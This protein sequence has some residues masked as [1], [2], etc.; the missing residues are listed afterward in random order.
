MKRDELRSLAERLESLTD[1][2]NRDYRYNETLADAVA[3]LRQI[4][5]AQPVAWRNEVRGTGEHRNIPE[6]EWRTYGITDSKTAADAHIE[7]CRD[8][9]EGRAIPLFTLPLED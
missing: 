7:N 6:T 3:F 5:E 4:A 8:G 9:I 2:S 1:C